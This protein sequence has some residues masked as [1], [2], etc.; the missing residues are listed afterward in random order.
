MW[1]WKSINILLTNQIIT[2]PQMCNANVW[3]RTQKDEND[4]CKTSYKKSFID[5]IVIF[6]RKLPSSINICINRKTL[7]IFNQCR[8]W[9]Y[10][11]TR[12]L[13]S[14]L[15]NSVLAITIQSPGGE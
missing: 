12:G 11:L 6:L 3:R 7:K 10:K 1:S 4:K 8:T 13:R 9:L 2:L 15:N 14:R 5:K